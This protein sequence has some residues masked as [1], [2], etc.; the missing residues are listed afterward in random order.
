MQVIPT[1]TLDEQRR[2]CYTLCMFRILYDWGTEGHSF[3][4]GVYESVDGAVKAAF[5]NNFGSKFII[6]KVID[7][8]VK[9]V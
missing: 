6:V 1:P 8:E 3:Y 5:A 2:A 7:W 4:D 9:E